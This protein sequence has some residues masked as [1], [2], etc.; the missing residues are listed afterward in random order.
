MGVTHTLCLQVL[1][2][3]LYARKKANIEEMT[4]HLCAQEPGLQLRGFT[5][6]AHTLRTGPTTA[7]GK[8]CYSTV[9]VLRMLSV[10]PGGAAPGLRQPFRQRSCSASW[11]V[12]Y[13]AELQNPAAETPNVNA[14]DGVT[15]QEV[16]LGTVMSW[17]SPS[18]LLNIAACERA[19]LGRVLRQLLPFHGRR[20]MPMLWKVGLDRQASAAPAA[21]LNFEPILWEF[22]EWF[23]DMG[24]QL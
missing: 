4:G 5:I 24:S 21:A 23:W 14:A 10:L 11:L 3:M 7:A 15:A 19:V 1:L 22:T 20:S 6:R 18:L 17:T 13:Y 16:E 2:R 12:A 8:S 9:G